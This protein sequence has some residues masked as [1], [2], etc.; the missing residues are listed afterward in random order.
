MLVTTL[1][2]RSLVARSLE[3]MAYIEA[4]VPLADSIDDVMTPM[5]IAAERVA[6]ALRPSLFVLPTTRCLAL[7]VRDVSEADVGASVALGMRV[8]IVRRGEVIARGRWYQGTGEASVSGRPVLVRFG[9]YDPVGNQNGPMTVSLEELLAEVDCVV[10]FTTDEEMALAA[11]GY[12]SY[13]RGSFERPL[14]ELVGR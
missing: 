13:W 6:A 12:G 8:E 4:R 1:V 5:P 9:P 10:R 7:S 3:G 11:I 2:V 14:K